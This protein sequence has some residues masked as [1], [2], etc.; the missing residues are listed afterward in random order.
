MKFLATPR[1]LT[2]PT[3]PSSTLLAVVAVFNDG[4]MLI[5]INASLVSGNTADAVGDNIDS[6]EALL[7]SSDYNLFGFNNQA[8]LSGVT[9]GANDI[10][11][12]ATN[13]SDIFSPTLADNGRITPTHNL[14]EN[15]PAVDAIM[16]GNCSTANDQTGFIRGNDGNDDM[17]AG[18]DIGSIEFQAARPDL[19]FIDGFESSAN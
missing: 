6:S 10:I 3:P 7:I 13:L 19:I 5:T 16:P 4:E 2:S 11:P 8:G 9:L 14:S 18:C 15:R 12:S 1:P 17:L